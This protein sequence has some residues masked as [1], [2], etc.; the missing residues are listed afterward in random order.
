MFFFQEKRNQ[1]L[2]LCRISWIV[3][4]VDTTRPD[5]KA[6]HQVLTIQK[7]EAKDAGNYSCSDGEN[8]Q[9]FYVQPIL[10]PKIIKK[11]PS[12]MQVS[13]GQDVT[14][15]C[16][17]E[18][19]P[20]DEYRHGIHWHRED[21]DGK[22]YS[23]DA[24]TNLSNK[25]QITTI[26]QTHL[27]VTL[28]LKSVAKRDNG[29][30]LCNIVNPRDGITMSKAT[31]V[32]VL[33]VPQ[34]RI[35]FVKAVGMDKIFMNW[36]IN[37]GNS[38]V[39]H[40]RLQY[41]VEGNSTFTYYNNKINGNATSHMIRGLIPNTNYKLKLQAINKIGDGSPYLYNEFIKTLDKDPDFVPVIEVKGSSHTTITI[42]WQPPAQHELD[43]IH[44]YELIVKRTGDDP[45]SE[46]EEAIHP[47]NS[48]NLPYMFDNLKS[49]TEYH[50]MVRA[51][52]DL[53]KFCGN[54]SV[55]VTGTTMDGAPSKPLNLKVTCAYA[56]ISS[57]S[58]VEISWDPPETPN[59]I[60]NVYQ[61]VLTG[62]AAYR[63]GNNQYRNDTF[64]PKSKYEEKVGKTVYDSVPANTNYTVKVWAI[65]RNKQRPGEMAEAHCRMPPTVPDNL[66]KFLWGRVKNGNNWIFGLNMPKIS[67]RNGPICCY[68]VYI[69]RLPSNQQNQLNPD[70]IEVRES[71]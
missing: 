24:T 57:R 28:E 68:L 32:L 1:T 59:G 66:G 6:F 44:Y 17:I 56:N 31:S 29:T 47:Q 20:V 54:W 2:C 63:T 27:N 41:L 58:S 40:Y 43:Y 22:E 12:A 16:Y 5:G 60:I 51:C 18:L 25:T 23:G 19:F 3:T 4:Q 50:F 39:T 8:H 46:M 14:I 26:N 69:V 38:N 33:D 49:A 61:T 53:T 13:I 62:M 48:R 67:E 55:P 45:A 64:G 42:G 7:V 10:E 35:D 71:C 15:F 70:K 34:V 9:H 36:T 52:S 65:T 37:D 21:V 11:S 30:Y